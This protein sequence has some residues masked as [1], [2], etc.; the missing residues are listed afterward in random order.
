MKTVIT[1][2][3]LQ[4]EI[5][6]NGQPIRESE[7]RQDLAQLVN[8]ITKHPEKIINIIIAKNHINININH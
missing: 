6:I 4:T 2:K 5:L 1:Q 8:D 3:D 7:R